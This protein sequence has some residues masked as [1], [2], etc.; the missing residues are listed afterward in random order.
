MVADLENIKWEEEFK[1]LDANLMWER[2]LEIL[3]RLATKHIPKSKPKARNSPGKPL[4]M[5]DRAMTKVRKKYAAWRRYID[6]MDG[7]DYEEY[8]RARNQARWEIRK[9]QKEFE[10]SIVRNIKENPKP[11]YKYTRSKLTTKSDIGELEMDG[12]VARTDEEKANMFNSFFSSVFSPED[13]SNI[14]EFE[15]RMVKEILENIE[16]SSADLIK[17]LKKLKTCKAAG[18]DNLHPRVLKEGAESLGAPLEMIFKKSPDTGLLPT[19]WKLGKVIPIF[20][21]GSRR[22]PTNFRPVSLTS[23]VCKIMEACI[24]DEILQHLNENKLFTQFQYGFI[25][26]KSTIS[27]LLHTTDCHTG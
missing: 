3:N 26:G 16:F 15:S 5:N 7:K 2:F 14:P 23:V 1:D 13:T 4:W 17:R 21:K 12:K 19:S 20:K 27:Q 6:T 11:F 18:P 10:E 25:Q 24:R 22:L 9:A 8:C